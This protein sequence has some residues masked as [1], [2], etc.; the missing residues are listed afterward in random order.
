MAGAPVDTPTPANEKLA[1]CGYLHYSVFEVTYGW[2][3]AFRIRMSRDMC[4]DVCGLLLMWEDSSNNPVAR[5]APLFTGFH[6]LSDLPY[7]WWRMRHDPDRAYVGIKGHNDNTGRR[8]S[9]AVDQT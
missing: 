8:G 6:Q 2:T 7:W 1:E 9:G 4:D 5:Q 3:R